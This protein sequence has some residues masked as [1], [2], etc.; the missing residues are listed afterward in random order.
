[1]AAGAAGA[2]VEETAANTQALGVDVA[3][4]VEDTVTWHRRR[5]QAQGSTP[6]LHIVDL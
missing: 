1:M 2:F 5:S 3:P 6:R 4:N